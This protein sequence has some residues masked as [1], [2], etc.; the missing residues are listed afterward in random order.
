MNKSLLAAAAGI[1]LTALGAF[2]ARHPQST[3]GRT[4]E[5]AVVS[6]F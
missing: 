1:T 6:V 5:Y 3:E 4:E 2:I